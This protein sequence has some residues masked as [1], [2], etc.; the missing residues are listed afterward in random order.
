MPRSYLTVTVK[1]VPATIQF[2]RDAFGIPV[3]QTRSEDGLE[4]AQLDVGQTVLYLLPVE[5]S[6][7]NMAW[8]EPPA[9]ADDRVPHVRLSI[10]TTGLGIMVQTAT[11]FG[12]VLVDEHMTGLEHV[13]CLRDPDGFLIELRS[14][15]PAADAT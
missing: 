15:L 4:F 11:W 2:Y 10:P 6:R 9:L 1:D 5:W 7:R 14:K 8:R 13:A 3:N 12:V